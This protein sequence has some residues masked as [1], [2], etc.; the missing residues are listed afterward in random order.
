VKTSK[1][2]AAMVAESNEV[3]LFPGQRRLHNHPAKN[4]IGI[5]YSKDE[6][7]NEQSWELKRLAKS[8]S[9]RS[10]RTESG[11]AARPSSADFLQP[12]E[13]GDDGFLL[14]DQSEMPLEMFDHHSKAANE[15]TPQEWLASKSK[16][17]AQYYSGQKWFWRPCTVVDYDEQASKFVIQ[18]SGQAHL[19]K[20]R[21]YGCVSQESQHINV[22]S[23]ALFI[24]G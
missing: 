14:L 19:K 2:G 10:S 17:R 3:K 11:P 20:V 12:V 8:M 6:S 22:P 16:A 13:P 23:A 18:Y 24:V 4:G 5:V 15:K 1:F 21:T 7:C 9:V